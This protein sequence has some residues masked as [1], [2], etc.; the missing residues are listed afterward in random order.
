[1]KV[2]LQKIWKEWKSKRRKLKRRLKDLNILSEKKLNVTCNECNKTFQRNG[3][4]KQHVQFIHMGILFNCD[5]KTTK[6]D[7][8]KQHIEVNSTSLLTKEKKMKS[9][10]LQKMKV[11]LQKRWKEWQTKIRTV[12]RKIKEWKGRRRKELKRKIQKS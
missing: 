12:K 9:Q 3:H 4:L 7:N 1:M 10:I 6:D 11:N 8:M 2:N 5:N